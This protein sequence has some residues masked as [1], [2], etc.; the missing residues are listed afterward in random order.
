[1]SEN[2]L[3]SLKAHLFI[4]TS[5]QFKTNGEELSDAEL[6]VNFRST[7][8][9]MAT[10][11]WGKQN[12][13]VSAVKCLGECERGIASVLYPKKEWRCSLRPGDEASMIDWINSS[14]T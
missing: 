9:K 3:P 1:M 6:A 4:C 12:V 7:V 10:E 11:K 5:C 8:K 2:N 13:R 14:I